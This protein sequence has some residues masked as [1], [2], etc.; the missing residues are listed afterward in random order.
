[1]VSKRS[2][3]SSRCLLLFNLT[4]LLALSAVLPGYAQSG[5]RQ[6]DQSSPTT[7]VRAHVTQPVDVQNLVPLRGNVHPLARAEYDRG[8]AP[9]DL[10]MQRMLLVLRRADD[11]EAALRQLLEDQQVKSSA[12]YH[13]WLTPE[14]FGQRFGPADAD[15][16]AVTDWLA[17][18]GFVVNQVAAGR[19]V[20]EFSGTAGLVRQGLHTEIHKFAVNGKEHWANVRDP[21]IPAALAPVVAGIA[22]LN[23]FPRRPLSRNLGAFSRSKLTGEVQPLFT[24]P[25]SYGNYYVLAPMDFATIYNLLPLWTAGT[26]GTG[27]TIAVVGETNINV[28][29]VLSFR[30]LFGLPVSYPNVILNGPDPGINGD[31]VEAVLDVEWSGAVARGATIDLVV[32]E[33]TEATYGVDLSALYIIDNN[34]APVMSESYGSCEADLGTGG[35]AFYNTLWE[36]AAA[37]GITVVI[38]SGDSGS[39]TCDVYPETAAKYGLAVNGLASTPFSVAVGG[40][41]FD[42]ANT[43]STYWN[44]TNSSTWSSAKSYIPESTWND[45][46]ARTGLSASCASV[47]SHGTDLIAGGGGASNCVT[48]TGTFPDFTC[49]GGYPKPSW[50]SGTGVPNDSARDLPDLSLFAGDGFNRSF[51]AVCEA[52]AVSPYASCNPSAY[53]WSFTGGGGASASAQ[54]FAGIMALVN[55][56][57]GRQGNANFVLY[58]LAAKSENSCASNA[59]MAPGAS[60]SSCV[61]Y[62]VVKGNNSVA[63]VGGSPNC[64]NTNTAAGQYGIM[65]TSAGGTTPAW[66]TTSGYDRAT[67]LGTVNIANLV[68][69]WTSVSFSPSTTTLSL[70]TTPPTDPLTLA[71]GQPVNFTINVAPKSG[72]GTPTGDVSLIAQTSSNPNSSTIGIASFTLSGGSIASTTNML[73]GGSYNV[74]AHYA[75]NGTY[76]GSDSDPVPVTVST[77]SSLTSVSLVTYNP[78]TQVLTYGATSAVYGSPYLLRVDVTS[79][80]G[81]LCAPSQYPD[82]GVPFYPCPTGKVTVTPPPPEVNAPWSATPGTYTLNSQGYAEDQ[83]AQLP[84]G[85]NNLVA[86]YQGDSSYNSSM[87]PTVPITITPAPTTITISAPS[88]N[89]GTNVPVAVTISTQSYGAG[90]TG[91]VQFLNDGA[92]VGSPFWVY[93]SAYSTSTGAYAALQTTLYP[94][95]PA[96]ADSITAQYNGDTNYAASTTAASITV[97]VTDFGMSANPSSITIP[98]PGQSGTSTITLAPL[99]GFTG[100]VNLNCVSLYTSITCTISPASLNV[101]GTSG[102]TATFTV[103]TT[104]Q[105]S[106]APPTLQPRLLPGSRL[107]AGWLWPLVGLLVVATLMSLAAARRRAAVW[108]FAT[109]LVVGIWAACGGSGGGSARAPVV[110]LAP[111]SLAF[112]QQATGSTSAPR[113]VILS[114]NG[115]APLVTS[116]VTVGGANPGDFAQTNTCSS[117]LATGANCAINVTFTP[118]ATG[119]RSASLTI[120]DNARGSPHTINLTGTGVVAP[121]VS[122]SAF[123]L[124]FG[125]ENM[126]L[127]SA[128]QTVTL[129]NTGNAL[130]SITSML[131]SGTNQWDYAQTNDCGNSVPEGSTCRISVTFTPTYPYDYTSHAS[132]VIS[133][134]ASPSSQIV[135]LTGSGIPPPTQPGPYSISVSAISGSDSHSLNVSVNVQ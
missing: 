36:Q 42:D 45:S 72:S 111:S 114:N 13:A 32:S 89:V 25:T 55:Q 27:Q 24:V 133:D 69:K 105:V 31:E 5:N 107:P 26:D 4:L 23:N 128:P 82:V 109:A 94:P 76:G 35:N 129:S 102:A 93:G 123:N 88:S 52:D 108:L 56:K 9:D 74:I 8:V 12:S 21:E 44:S 132:L 14:E 20:I 66:I 16:Q 73:P 15:I 96:G 104:A 130:L 63:C 30:N 6:A 92:P 84:G 134:N 40:T 99:N 50:Q 120:T 46:C 47:S 71:H 81:Q 49:S 101:S 65:T 29:D 70:S 126:G 100:T 97:N 18:Q 78:S 61:F 67:G 62:D 91:T 68:N 119:A 22:S 34:L 3:S 33:S 103:K 90:P 125:Q 43:W 127:T 124:T 28:S 86:N 37:Q 41:D 122:L 7:P 2:E 87:S 51:Y 19:T 58:P 53:Q 116:S 135:S 98:A 79:S 113:S 115:N 85:T 60:S 131:I 106:A 54:V 80:S 118:S 77:E 117:S 121:A 17:G 112:G 110:N 59:T 48:S 1:M 64:S 83:Y 95:L 39:A 57:Y 10:P 38:A 75:G 11:Q